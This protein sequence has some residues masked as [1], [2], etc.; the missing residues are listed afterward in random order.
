[1]RDA[2]GQMER[3]GGR[4]LTNDSADFFALPIVRALACMR[5]GRP[6]FSCATSSNTLQQGRFVCFLFKR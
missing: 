2:K 3:Q 6:T 5:K 4:S 1:M